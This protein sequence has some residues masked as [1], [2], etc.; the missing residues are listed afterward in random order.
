MEVYND[1]DSL[2]ERFCIM[3][4]DGGLSD[5]SAI[6]SLSDKEL[7]AEKSDSPPS[8]VIMQNLSKR[9]SQSLYTSI[10]VFTP[11][12]QNACKS[13]TFRDYLLSKNLSVLYIHHQESFCNL[14]CF[15]TVF[16]FWTTYNLNPICTIQPQRTCS[17][18]QTCE[19]IYIVCRFRFLFHS[20]NRYF[21]RFHI[22]R[23]LNLLF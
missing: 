19:Q 16:L 23:Y 6:N 5:F 12:S 2:F 14:Y 13:Y 11:S 15:V 4:V 21:S 9:L 3:T 7:M 22:F 18:R 1:W 10:I 20:I 8:T 17:N